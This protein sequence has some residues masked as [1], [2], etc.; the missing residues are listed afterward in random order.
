MTDPTQ[1][2]TQDEDHTDTPLTPVPV[3]PPGYTPPPG[4][5]PDEL[6]PPGVPGDY[7]EDPP[8]PLADDE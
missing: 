1:A 2:P 3:E 5:D 7:P 4:T 8:P 6:L